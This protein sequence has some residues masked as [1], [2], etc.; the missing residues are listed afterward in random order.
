MSDKFTPA[1]IEMCLDAHEAAGVVRGVL[2][3]EARRVYTVL[4]Y[5]TLPDALAEIKRLRAELSDAQLLQEEIVSM[6]QAEG[7]EP[8]TPVEAVHDVIEELC[9]VRRGNAALRDQLREATAARIEMI[10]ER[11]AARHIAEEFAAERDALYTAY[12]VLKTQPDAQR[13]ALWIIAEQ[14]VSGDGERMREKAR[15][16]GMADKPGVEE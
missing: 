7:V 4:A 5:N 11:N 12:A 2:N 1:F 3:P 8:N 13:A 15:A 16:A 14:E 9:D 10:A 6:C